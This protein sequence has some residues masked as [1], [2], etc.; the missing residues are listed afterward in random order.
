MK[1]APAC[2]PARCLMRSWCRSRPS[3]ALPVARPIF[4]WPVSLAQ[5]VISCRQ[6]CA[7][8]SRPISSFPVAARLSALIDALAQRWKAEGEVQLAKLAAGLK[9]I[10]EA[11]EQQAVDADGDVS[12]F[13]YTMF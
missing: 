3:D 7:P 8:C 4:R 13:C 5:R 9:A 1:I 10:A 2:W 11:L 6:W 12:I